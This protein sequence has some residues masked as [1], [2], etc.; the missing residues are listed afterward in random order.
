MQPGLFIGVGC[1]SP[2]LPNSSLR[3][4]SLRG[5]F[6]KRQA[7]LSESGVD[8][9]VDDNG[10]SKTM[11]AMEE[12]LAPTINKMKEAIDQQ[13]PVLVHCSAGRQRSATVVAAYLMAFHGM[14]LDATLEFMKRKKPDVFF[15]E[16][17]FM[18]VLRRFSK[19]MTHF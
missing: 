17:N 18:P 4:H 3:P 8:I 2:R 10:S 16:A 9:K 1:S 11:H 14:D 13:V 6:N 15:P 7:V 12:A 5:E 19:N